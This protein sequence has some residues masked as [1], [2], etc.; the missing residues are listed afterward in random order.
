LVILLTGRQ[1]VYWFEYQVNKNYIAKNLCVKKDVVN[2]CCQGKCFVEKEMAS[3]EISTSTQPTEKPIFLVQ[4]EVVSNHIAFE[5]LSIP[6]PYYIDLSH[7]LTHFYTFS[8]LEAHLLIIEHP[9]TLF[10][11]A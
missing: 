9:P 6:S 2:N 8:L 4:I 1:S 5:N 7:K 10:W 3:A 11:L